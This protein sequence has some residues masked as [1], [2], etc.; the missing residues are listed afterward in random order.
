[1]AVKPCLVCGDLTPSGSYCA[2]HRPRKR[3]TPSTRAWAR[4]GSRRLRERV[5]RRDGFRCVRCGSRE[6]LE[7][8]HRLPVSEGGAHVPENL[9]TRCHGCH[10]AEHR[11]A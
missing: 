3:P 4:P 10:R 8:H 6:R 11:A 9:E 1:M 2:L 5:L 7:V